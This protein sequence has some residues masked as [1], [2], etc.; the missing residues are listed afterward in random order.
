MR[1]LGNRGLFSKIVEDK[2]PMIPDCFFEGAK[3]SELISSFIAFDIE[4][5]SPYGFPSNM[6]AP[7]VN[8]SLVIPLPRKGILSLSVIGEPCLESQMLNLL[9][10]LLE[11]FRGS[12]LFT[13]NGTKFD[14]EYVIQRGKAY[15][16][17]FRD[18]FEGFW[19]IDV[20]RL[21]KLCGIHLPGYAQKGVERFFGI[22]RVIND[23]SG[24]VYHMF[25]REFLK[26][27]SLKPMFY[28]IEDSFGCLRILNMILKLREKELI[29][30]FFI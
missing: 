24:R 1:A 26:V 28:N 2:P 20:Y 9:H 19:H 4:T 6:E 7:V 16:L 15:E 27:G 23:V 3:V 17:D 8:F 14:I 13:Y 18:V 5:F 29:S 12:Y 22:P 10:R 25:Y 11:S 21:L 30:Q